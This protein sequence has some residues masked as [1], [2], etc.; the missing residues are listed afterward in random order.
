MTKDVLFDPTDH[1][2]DV[3]PPESRPRP[4]DLYDTTEFE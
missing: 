3:S 4:G 2:D 1:R